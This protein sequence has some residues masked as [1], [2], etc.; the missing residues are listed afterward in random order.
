[1]PMP[2]PRSDFLSVLGCDEHEFRSLMRGRPVTPGEVEAA[3]R[4][5]YPWRQH[6]HDHASYWVTIGQAARILGSS[7]TTVRRL[8]E[9]GEIPHIVHISGV[10]LMARRDVEGMRQ[11]LAR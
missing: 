6:V 5:H 10:R 2:Q 4:R 9:H 7:S 11:A 3:A 8:L 1:M